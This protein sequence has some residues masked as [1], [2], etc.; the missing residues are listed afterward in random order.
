MISKFCIKCKETK[1][2]EEFSCTSTKNHFKKSKLTHQVYC[3]GC[4]AAYAREWRK[5]HKNYQGSGRVNSIPEADRFLMSA[6]RQ[7]ITDAKVRCKKLK[8]DAPTLVDTHLYELFLK[9]NRSCA[10]TGAPLSLITDNPLC[11]SLDQID[12]RKG[13]VAGNVQWL[14]WCVNRAKGDLSTEHFY[15]MC[16]AVLGYRKVQRLSKGGEIQTE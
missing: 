1:L 6:I 16:D 7:R 9:Q 4:C 3:K 10:L 2:I 13:Y 8:K 11:L 14:A 12:P 5:T 15:E